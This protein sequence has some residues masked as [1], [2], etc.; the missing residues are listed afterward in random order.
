VC[1]LPPRGVDVEKP[2]ATN[3]PMPVHAESALNLCYLTFACSHLNNLTKL[4]QPLELMNASLRL[5]LVSIR[6][7]NAAAF[8]KDG[9]LRRTQSTG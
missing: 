5:P 1:E 4:C 2:P 8:P 6:P 9:L 7:A 3:A